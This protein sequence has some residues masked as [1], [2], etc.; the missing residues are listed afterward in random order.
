MWVQEYTKQRYLR[1]KH[2]KVGSHRRL[3]RVTFAVQYAGCREVEERSVSMS[4]T[5][6]HAASPPV[7]AQVAGM[8]DEEAG[9]SAP[10]GPSNYKGFVAGVFS[11]IAK[12]SVGYD[13]R[14][15]RNGL[16]ERL[17]TDQAPLRYDQSPPPN[18]FT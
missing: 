14:K 10:K 17:T 8:Q 11:G 4:A 3:F 6:K 13:H 2:T 16:T 7:A 9:V 12:L 5:V 1:S 18:I 15:E